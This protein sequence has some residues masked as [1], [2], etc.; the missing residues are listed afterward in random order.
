MYKPTLY[1]LSGVAGCGKSTWVQN[2]L[3][4]DK[5]RSLEPM[6]EY[7]SRDEVRFSMVKEEDDY[8]SK[9]KQVFNE[10]VNRIVKSLEDTYVVNT[11]ADA[12]QLNEVSRL[13]LINA[14][15]K[16][17]PSLDFDVVVVYFDVPLEVCQFRNA[18]RSG[19]ARVPEN[20]IAKMYGSLEFPKCH[21]NLVKVEIVRD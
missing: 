19:R 14:I 20:V 11:I 2:K 21:K 10:Y 17:R 4:E 3:K 13:K 6:W 1:I 18:K 7:V 15:K 5:T 8:F 9:E 16:M 12:T